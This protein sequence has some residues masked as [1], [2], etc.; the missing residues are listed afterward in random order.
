MIITACRVLFGLDYWQLFRLLTP[1]VVYMSELLIWDDAMTRGADT[2]RRGGPVP[3]W[4]LHNN[5]FHRSLHPSL[6][7][8]CFDR[9]VTGKATNY[10][11]IVLCPTETRPTSRVVCASPS[12]VSDCD[13]HVV[14]SFVFCYAAWQAWSF[15]GHTATLPHIDRL[16]IRAFGGSCG[17]PC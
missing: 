3:E 10:V 6:D 12:L 9:L 15:G 4:D 5:R 13:P 14:G 17:T 16:P 1:S 8:L 7:G 11:P 2:E